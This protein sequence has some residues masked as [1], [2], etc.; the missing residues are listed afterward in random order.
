MTH[1]LRLL[2][3]ELVRDVTTSL[4]YPLEL[5]AGLVIMFA[6]FMGLYTGARSLAGGAVIAGSHE[7]LVV[8]FCMWFL[9]I[10]SINSMSVD[11]ENEARQGTLEQLFLCAPSFTALLW[12][13]GTVHL[14]TGSSMVI[15]LSLLLQWATGHWL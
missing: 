10:V 13:R 12:V 2:R 1:T 8:R 11:I 15:A 3:A 9:A 6:L 5:L 7:L 4:R 14:F